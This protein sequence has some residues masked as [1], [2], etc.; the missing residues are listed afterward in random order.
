MIMWSPKMKIDIDN[1]LPADWIGSICLLF[2]PDAFGHKPTQNRHVE[3]GRCVVDAVFTEGSE[4][5][6]T[7]NPVQVDKSVVRGPDLE[8]FG[9]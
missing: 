5:I 4:I 9:P 8:L 3:V 2:L 1:I 7:A 6:A